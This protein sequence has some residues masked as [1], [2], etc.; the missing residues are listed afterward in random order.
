MR[1]MATDLVFRPKGRSNESPGSILLRFS[2]AIYEQPTTVLQA[3]GIDVRDLADLVRQ[4][5][6]GDTQVLAQIADLS[7]WNLLPAIQE[8]ATGR[9]H[10]DWLSANAASVCPQCAADGLL[11][12]SHDVREIDTCTLHG[13]QLLTYCPHCEERISWSRPSLTHCKCH[14]ALDKLIP[15]SQSSSQFAQAIENFLQNN[16]ESDITRLIFH[17]RLLMERYGLTAE[18]AA[19]ATLE[20]MKYNTD[21][22]TRS[23]ARFSLGHPKLNIRA[24]IAPLKPIFEALDIDSSEMISKILLKRTQVKAWSLPDTYYLTRKDLIF[25]LQTTP[26]TTNEILSSHFKSYN[27]DLRR[28]SLEAAETFFNHL[29]TTNIAIVS[30]NYPTLQEIHAATK[31]PYSELVGAII[32]GQYK[33]TSSMGEFGLASIRIDYELGTGRDIPE[34]FMTQRE[35]ECFT[36]LYGVAITAARESGLLKASTQPDRWNRYLFKKAD[37]EHFIQNYITCGQLAK[38]LATSPKTLK[39]KLEYLGI[40]PVCGPDIDGTA[41]YIFKSS[42]VAGLTKSQL[43]LAEEHYNGAGRKGPSE[44]S[45]NTEFWMSASEVIEFLNVSGNQLTYMTRKTPLVEGKPEFAPATKRYF[46]R[47]SVIKT[48]SFIQTLVTID[49]LSESTHLGRKRVLRRLKSL[50]KDVVVVINNIDYVP[51]EEAERFKAHCRD[52]WCSQTASEYLDC[53]R[54]DINNWR[55]LGQLDPIPSTDPNYIGTPHLYLKEQIVEF[56]RNKYRHQEV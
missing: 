26:K 15:A 50:I 28:I 34:G 2:G 56:R 35:V 22:L 47:D 25:A 45:L 43:R 36:N 10:R 11:P 46:K 8:K 21:M 19:E 51:F 29:E 55:R 24:V 5:W 4:F 3:Q 23:M 49:A 39:K 41:L 42:V 54:F 16:Q 20:L 44:R 12:A 9:S 17:R 33:P 30:N 40:V 48:K 37:I 53:S 1:K 32:A 13:L 27:N 52:Y 7:E 6:R 18:I 38:R 14:K 31:K